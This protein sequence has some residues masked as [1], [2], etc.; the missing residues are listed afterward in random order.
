MT[1]QHNLKALYTRTIVVRLTKNSASER[2]AG[3]KANRNQSI[4]ACFLYLYQAGRPDHMLPIQT[5]TLSLTLY[6]IGRK[7]GQ[8]VSYYFAVSEEVAE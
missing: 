7:H 3:R 5:I 4:N 1:V 6:G 2:P 8:A